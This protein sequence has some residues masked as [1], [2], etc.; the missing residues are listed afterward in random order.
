VLQEI[1]RV[2]HHSHDALGEHVSVQPFH[3]RIEGE[4]V[5]AGRTA[6]DQV[7]QAVLAP[8]LD[9]E[10]GDL[11]LNRPAPGLEVTEFIVE[12]DRRPL[13]APKVVRPRILNFIDRYTELTSQWVK[14][15]TRTR[16]HALLT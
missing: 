5:Q 14:A 6:D 8:R 12:N 3:A 16:A 7:D 4:L 2:V 1:H 11:L 13:R 10:G 9:R 15:V